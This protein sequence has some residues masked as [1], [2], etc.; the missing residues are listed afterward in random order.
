M[1][2]N[3]LGARVSINRPPKLIF[4]TREISSCPAQR[5]STQTFA[6]VSTREVNLLD[7]AGVFNMLNRPAVFA[8]VAK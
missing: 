5:Q 1:E 8:E 7:G 4:P 3:P 2:P 6:G